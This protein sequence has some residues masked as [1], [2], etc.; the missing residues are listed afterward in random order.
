M[1]LPLALSFLCGS[2]LKILFVFYC[3][4]L[5]PG[6]IECMEYVDDLEEKQCLRSNDLAENKLEVVDVFARENVCTVIL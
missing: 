1:H 4:S 3:L 6:E 2:L 5:C